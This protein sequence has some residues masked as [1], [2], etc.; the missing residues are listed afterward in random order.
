MSLIRNTGER[1][2]IWPP[3][4]YSSLVQVHTE[5]GGLWEDVLRAAEADDGLHDGQAEDRGEHGQGDVPG[6][7]HGQ[8]AEEDL[9]HLH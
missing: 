8:D 4:L 1:S 6:E 2:S 5:H 7:A 3:N 9:R